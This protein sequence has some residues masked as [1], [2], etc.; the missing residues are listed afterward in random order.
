MTRYYN[1][2]LNNVY[3][4]DQFNLGPVVFGPQALIAPGVAVPCV[5]GVG[6][7]W[8]II[9]S[10][11]LENL[12]N[13]PG[14]ALK[15]GGAVTNATGGQIQGSTAIYIAGA[16]GTVVN[17][18]QLHGTAGGVRLTAGGTVANGNTG[19]TLGYIVADQFGVKVTGGAGTVTNLGDIQSPFVPG[20]PG[21]GV[22]LGAGGQVTNGQSGASRGGHINAGQVGV[23]VSGPSA[24]V[25]NF[26][27]IGAYA[28]NVSGDAG[29]SLY[30]VD[31]GA[32]NNYGLILAQPPNGLQVSPAVGIALTGGTKTAGDQIVNRPVG[33]SAAL[34]SGPRAGIDIYGNVA[35]TVQNGG[36]I[37]GATG[38]N[39]ET[40]DLI[41]NTVFNAGT[42]TGTAGTAIQFGPGNDIL[43][44]KTGAVFNGKVDGGGGTNAVFLYTDTGTLTGIGTQFVNFQKVLFGPQAS[45]R[46]GVDTVTLPS[47][48]FAHRGDSIDFTALAA[49]SASYAGGVVTLRNGTVPVAQVNLTTPYTHKAFTVSPD[50]GGGSLLRVAPAIPADFDASGASD[51]LWRNDDGQAAIWLLAGTTPGAQRFTGP[52]PGPSW[53]IKGNG[54]FDN[55]GEAGILW[56]NSDGQA[57]IWLID[58]V[59]LAGAAL[60]GPN[61]GA[62]WHVAAAGAVR[63]DG[64]GDILWQNDDGQA[65]I[66]LM[67]G[68]TPIF[69]G[70]IGANPGP[71]WHLLAAADLDGDALSDLLWQ[72]SDGQVAVWLMDG[73]VPIA[74]TVIGFNPGSSWHVRAAGDL[75]GDGRADIVWQNDDG[76]VAVWLMNGATPTLGALVGGRTGSDW[77]LIATADINGDGK[78]DLLWQNGDGQA[79]VWLMNGMVS[80]LQ[81]LVGADPGPSWHLQSG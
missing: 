62:S 50:G 10:G 31:H 70:F 12:H 30:S 69:E 52:N 43:A 17:L 34:I 4:R 65:A 5:A 6:Y 27:I 18:A 57:A 45:W 29:L 40:V 56:Q 81:T 3:L 58:G 66:W 59:S 23:A 13:G 53:Q 80:T 20:N 25:T 26:A 24:V 35:A 7:P 46:V 28:A 76:Q 48:P 32:V 74:Q 60:I 42:I 37:R 33:N 79:G 51:F 8:T 73:T 77:H 1:T 19:G 16:A 47:F 41:A 2:T 68:T 39:V 38:I 22:Y 64:D 67:N 71:S 14:V 78:S 75:D 15:A 36:T 63:G 11:G 61:P 44:P 55:S 54:Y 9:N 72:N 21:I 49:N